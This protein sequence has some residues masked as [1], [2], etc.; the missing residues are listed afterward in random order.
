MEAYVGGVLKKILISEGKTAK[1]G[2]VLAII[3]AEGEVISEAA[4]SIAAAEPIKVERGPAQ[5]PEPAV[6]AVKEPAE[7]P[8]EGAGVGSMKASPVARKMAADKGIDLARIR[9]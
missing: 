4:A 6:S 2:E 9:G 7:S 3:G 5:L 8:R 1:V